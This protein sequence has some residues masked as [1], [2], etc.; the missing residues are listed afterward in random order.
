MINKQAQSKRRH[1]RVRA[2][3]KGTASR[4]RVSV[5]TSLNGM[6]VQLIDDG[7]GQTLISGQDKSFPGS[8]TAKASALGKDMAAKAKKAKIKEVVFDR[9]RRQYHGRVK[10]LADAM[11]EGGLVF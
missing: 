11:R 3:I 2:K 7:S 9:G 4:L 10:A 1:A 6:F 5:Y 8:K